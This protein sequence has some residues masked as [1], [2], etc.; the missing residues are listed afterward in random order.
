M[1]FESLGQRKWEQDK[2]SNKEKERHHLVSMWSRRTQC[3]FNR[4]PRKHP[5]HI[6]DNTED[7]INGLMLHKKSYTFIATLTVQ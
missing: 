3:V 6:E 7:K 2:D 1:N 5:H 4:P